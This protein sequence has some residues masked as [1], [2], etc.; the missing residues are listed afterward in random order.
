MALVGRLTAEHERVAD[1][2]LDALGALDAGDDAAA[3]SLVDAVVVAL[4]PHTRREESGLFP[5]L[6]RDADL[7][8][9]VDE[10]CDEHDDIHAGLAAAARGD[11]PAV[12]TALHVLR[13]H[14]DREEH[15]LFPAALATLTPE[16]WDRAHAASEDVD[17]DTDT[18]AGVGR[19]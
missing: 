5:E 12:R 8:P 13:R 6:R 3:R 1:L 4:G 19:G 18:A 14:I 11:W 7:A 10:L 2:A 16:Q 9:H 17:A 15:G